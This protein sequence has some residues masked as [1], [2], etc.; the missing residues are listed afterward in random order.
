MSEHAKETLPQD[1]NRRELICI[2]CPLG[3]RLDVTLDDGTITAIKGNLC[4]RG[5]DYA[6]T[7][8]LQPRRM[9][10]SLIA[11]PGSRIPLSVRT[12]TAIPKALIRPCLE[13]IRT[14]RVQLP[15]HIGD[16]IVTNILNSGVDLIA[17]RNLPE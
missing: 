14:I 16:V 2:G 11:V 8:V 1:Q 7:E 9:L 12:R 6:K 17:T 13:A 5:Q 4:R 10:T 15:V 3:C